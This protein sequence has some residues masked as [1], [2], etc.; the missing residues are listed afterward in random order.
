MSA[1]VV[2]ASTR[3]CHS[4]A[5]N[6][7]CACGSVSANAARTRSPRRAH[8]TPCARTVRGA[9]LF[10]LMSAVAAANASNVHA[11]EHSAARPQL[12]SF[13]HSVKLVARSAALKASH[14]YAS[15]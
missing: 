7:A 14:A 1:R 4:N 8:F 2:R 9:S 13:L 11:L 12:T 3:L 15:C 5:R 6:G 10:V